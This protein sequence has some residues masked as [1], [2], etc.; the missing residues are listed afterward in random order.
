MA[1]VHSILITCNLSSQSHSL[2]RFSVIKYPPSLLL[3]RN[4]PSLWGIPLHPGEAWQTTLGDG[5]LTPFIRG[6]GTETSPTPDVPPKFP[7]AV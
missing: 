5:F 7:V 4:Q 3:S 6:N 1:T 2:G